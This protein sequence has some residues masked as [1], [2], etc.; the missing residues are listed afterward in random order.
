MRPDH[1]DD[2]L[3]TI[4]VGLLCLSLA[5]LAWLAMVPQEPVAWVDYAPRTGP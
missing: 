5:V 3:C 2:A 4:A 1:T